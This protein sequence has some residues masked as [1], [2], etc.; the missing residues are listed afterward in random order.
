MFFNHYRCWKKEN[1]CS[2]SSLRILHTPGTFDPITYGH[3]DIIKRA[4]RVFD[5]VIIAVGENL[6]KEPLFTVEERVEMIKRVTQGLKNIKVDSFNELMVNYVQRKKINIVIR[7]LRMIS[8]FEYEFQMALT[9]RKLNPNIEIIFLM[10]NEAYSF[11]SS[12]LIKE[13][14]LLGADLSEF[15]PSY[16]AEKLKRKLK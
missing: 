10:P 16:V 9:N 2:E 5:E 13:I 7:G 12:K 1:N 6:L 4:S 15:V 3:I 11:L 8:D 14:A